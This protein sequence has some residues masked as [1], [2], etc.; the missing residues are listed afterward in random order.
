MKVANYPIDGFYKYEDECGNKFYHV[1]VNRE[2][3]VADIIQNQ[4]NFKAILRLNE[5]INKLPYGMDSLLKE[6]KKLIKGYGIKDIKNV[7][8][9][10][11][12][13][14]REKTD[15]PSWY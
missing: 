11:I 15:L 12:V 7:S 5:Y 9:F 13:D 4:G 10:S 6:F 2:V 14:V 3:V 8:I 1:L